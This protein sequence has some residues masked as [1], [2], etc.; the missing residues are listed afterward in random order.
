MTEKKDQQPKEVKAYE[1]PAIIGREPLEAV[2][3]VCDP[4]QGG[5]QQDTFPQTCGGFLT[6]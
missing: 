3:A 6:S 1:P 4:N 5:K 2:A